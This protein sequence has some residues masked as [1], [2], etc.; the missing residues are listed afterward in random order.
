MHTHVEMSPAPDRPRLC[1]SSPGL[2]SSCAKFVAGNAQVMMLR[3]YIQ[4]IQLFSKKIGIP[5]LKF[6]IL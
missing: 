6:E 5:L 3:S 2:S 1:V 4:A